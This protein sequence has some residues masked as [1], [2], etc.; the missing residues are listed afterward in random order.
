MGK[1]VLDEAVIKALA[2]DT[3]IRILKILSRRNKTLSEISRELNLSKPTLLDHLK[4]LNH[5]MLIAKIE[6]PESKFVYYTLTQ[7]GKGILDTSGKIKITLLLTTMLLS[8]TSSIFEITKY[9]SGAKIKVVTEFLKTSGQP[10]VPNEVELLYYNPLD[11][12]IGVIFLLL[13]CLLCYNLLK[14]VNR[15]RLRTMLIR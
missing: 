12:A 2:S 10:P 1:V 8:L 5:C 14:P 15:V 6:R 13:A 3:R 9:L 4:R 11:L 7:T